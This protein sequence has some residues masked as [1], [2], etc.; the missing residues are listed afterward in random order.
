MSL[1]KI[2]KAEQLCR[3]PKDNQEFRNPEYHKSFAEGLGIYSLLCMS[4]TLPPDDRLEAIISLFR[5]V[6]DEGTDMLNRWRDAIPHLSQEEKLDMVNLLTM[7][8]R[9]NRINS[10]DR[11]YTTVTLYNHAMIHICYDCFAEL[12]MDKEMMVDH[13]R[14]AARYLYATDDEEFKQ[15]AQEA[16]IE[17]IDTNVYKV[18]YR[19]ETIAGYIS[20]TGINTTLNATKLKVPY[21]EQF[22][23]G[24]Q[25]TFFYNEINEP[26]YR[27]L[28]GQ[29]ILQMECVD[30]EEKIDIG[31]ILLSISNDEMLSENIRADA[32]DVVLRLGKG[33]QKNE[34]RELLADMGYNSGNVKVENK[35]KTIY[36]DSQNIHQFSEQVDKFIEKIIKETNIEVRPYH[37]VHQDVSEK[38]RSLI[39]DPEEKFRAFKALNRISID[40]A[41]FTNYRITLS[42]IFVHVWTRIKGYQNPEIVNNLERRMIDELVDMGE[43]CSS[44][45][46]GRFVN[47]LSAYDDTLKISWDQQI[48]ANISGRMNARIRDC[49]DVE[50][51]GSLA[52]ATSELADDNDKE[53]YNNFVKENMES[54]R[55][56]LHEE[57]VGEGYVTREYF[58]QVFGDCSN[59]WQLEK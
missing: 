47:V 29:H 39:K 35:D 54:L 20:K 25:T 52:M 37:E 51:R 6:P 23:Y 41:Q 17:I 30:D 33:D 58:E 45:H 36:A 22:V 48:K 3:P 43:T 49:P 28:S 31:N 34:A 14:E 4:S 40:T 18:K 46:S 1:E 55:K 44:G 24:L 27:I 38:V 12:A 26:E 16:L 19:Y 21:D 13:R 8:I 50:V 9:D 2:A 59:E 15:I 7:V 5:T 57:F 56:E 42:E 32:A 53:I 10:H 11:I